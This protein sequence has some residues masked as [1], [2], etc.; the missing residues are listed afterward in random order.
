[1]IVQLSE[2]GQ[3]SYKNVICFQYKHMNLI[4]F[5]VGRQQMP[6]MHY[7]TK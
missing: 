4:L 1:M 6:H 3:H 2:K 5:I 7:L